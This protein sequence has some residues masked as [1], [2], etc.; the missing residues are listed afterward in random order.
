MAVE[1]LTFSFDAVVLLTVF[2]WQRVGAR[3]RQH[4][5]WGAGDPVLT[6][7]VLGAQ[8]AGRGHA[9]DVSTERT[10]AGADPLSHSAARYHRVLLGAVCKHINTVK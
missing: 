10:L 1:E 8:G 7:G 9:L 6:V 5:L 3:L 4:V 2:M